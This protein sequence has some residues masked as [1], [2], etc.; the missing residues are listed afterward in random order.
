MYIDGLVC[1]SFTISSMYKC[2]FTSTLTKVVYS[3]QS[4][5]F[6]VGNH[7]GSPVHHH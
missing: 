7:Y 4:A 5:F 2:T 1:A 3:P 6:S